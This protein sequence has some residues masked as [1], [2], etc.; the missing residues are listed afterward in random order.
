MEELLALGQKK[1]DKILKLELFRAFQDTLIRAFSG[2]PERMHSQDTFVRTLLMSLESI[3]SL[4]ESETDAKI[5]TKW[6]DE[7]LEKDHEGKWILKDTSRLEKYAS[8][9]RIYLQYE[10]RMK[11]LGYI[12]FSDMILASIRLVEQHGDIRA[13]LAEQYQFVLVDEY[14]DTNDAQLRL[15]TD[16]LALSENPNIFAV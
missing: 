13:N 9:A 14:Q 10:E 2:L 15:I 12:D 3:W 6:R 1:E 7:W 5:V 8:L 11:A 4:Q 16:I